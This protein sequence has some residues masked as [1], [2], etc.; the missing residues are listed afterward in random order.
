MYEIDVEFTIRSAL[1]VTDGFSIMLL[2]KEPNFP[3]DLGPTLGIREDFNGIGV[4]LYRS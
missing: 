1:E 4:L 2:K 3:D